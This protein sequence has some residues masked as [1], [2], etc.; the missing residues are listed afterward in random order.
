MILIGFE[1]EQSIAAIHVC[2]DLAIDWIVI[3]QIAHDSREDQVNPKQYLLH[4]STTAQLSASVDAYEPETINL[5]LTRGS[6]KQFAV[7]VDAASAIG[8][9]KHAYFLDR[10]TSPPHAVEAAIAAAHQPFNSKRP[11]LRMV[12]VAVHGLNAICRC[13]LGGTRIT[14]TPYSIYAVN[15]RTMTAEKVIGD[16]A[17]PYVIKGYR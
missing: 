13:F 11:L 2:C 4:D 10:P 8:F 3:E 16:Y 12:L 1:L 9:G 15:V 7:I 14:P 17:K 6:C 5:V